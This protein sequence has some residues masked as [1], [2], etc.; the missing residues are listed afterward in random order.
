M[1]LRYRPVLF[2]ATLRLRAAFEDATTASLAYSASIFGRVT[3]LYVRWIY[4]A[5]LRT[6]RCAHMAEP[7]SYFRR[8]MHFARLRQVF[9]PIDGI[10]AGRECELT[11]AFQV[12]HG[13]TRETIGRNDKRHKL[14]YS[15][16]E[17]KIYNSTK[18]VVSSFLQIS[19]V[20]E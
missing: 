19:K 8:P 14:V 20:C 10:I 18:V 6:A 3:N 1:L 15:H 7:G 9:P 4:R 2:A 5:T 17:C 11:A 13:Y 12:D 16:E